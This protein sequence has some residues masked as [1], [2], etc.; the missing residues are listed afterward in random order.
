M[1]CINGLSSLKKLVLFIRKFSFHSSASTSLFMK[2]FH[3][4]RVLPG[5]I[6]TLLVLHIR[7]RLN[8]LPILDRASWALIFTL[9]SWIQA[10][11]N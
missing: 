5:L 9:H 6:H 3:Q 4:T 11:C 10:C 1:F 7:L 2:L 8:L